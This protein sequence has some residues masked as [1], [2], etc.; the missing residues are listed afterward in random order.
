M[1]YY[2]GSPAPL[3][4]Q[5]VDASGNPVAVTTPPVATVT[6]PDG[7]TST[8]TAAAGAGATPQ[9]TATGTTAQPGHYLVAWSCAD[10]THPCAL[11]DAYDVLP[12]SERSLLSLAECKRALRISL[13]DTSEDD[14]VT[15]FAR[16][17]TDIVEWWC[18]P[19]LQQTVTEVI[20]SRGTEVMLSKPPVIALQAWTQVPAQLATAGISLPSPASPMIRTRLYGIEWPLT[21]LYVDQRRGVVIHTSGLPFF[22]CAYVWQYSAGRPSTPACIR[23]GFRAILKHIFGMERGGAASSGA[24]GAADEET[25][26]TPTGYA[27]PN[28]ALELMAP[29][30]I[31]AGGA[32]A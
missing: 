7:T 31:G 9:Y 29:E 22:Y 23:S 14:F 30:R 12:L 26:M 20:P 3:A 17:T 15:E 5:P 13:S 11:T 21:Q 32:F 16:S 19:V 1:P 6:A 25:T 10:A 27:V 2:E 24:L 18:G 4:F 8:P 28:R